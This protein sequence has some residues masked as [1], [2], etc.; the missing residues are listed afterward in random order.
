MGA[1]LAMTPTPFEPRGALRVNESMVRHT[2][3]GIGGPAE[4]FFVP[5]DECD[6]IGYLQSLDADHELLWLGLGSNLLVRDGGVSG[7]VIDTAKLNRLTIDEDYRVIAEAGVP[8]PKVAKL[9]RRGHLTGAEFMAGIPGS[10]GGALAMN[11]GAFGGETWDIVTRVW[12]VDRNG[13]KRERDAHDF[14]VGYRHVEGIGEEAFL[15]AELQLQA[16]ADGLAEQ[17]IK[18]LLKRRSDTQPLG[19]KSCG[20]VFT[21]PKDDHAARLIEACGLKGYQVGG[22]QISEK[23]ANF[24]INAGGASA[25]DVLAV[26]DHIQTVVADRFSVRLETEVRVVGTTSAANG[27]DA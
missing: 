9:C 21:N 6:L 18:A 2:V 26:I 15:A 23:H 5:A 17:R 8:C 13:V 1:C 20:S 10:I 27:D 24:I 19:L 25:E 11:A 16:D 7:T 14:T 22:A 12:T 4:Q 3:W